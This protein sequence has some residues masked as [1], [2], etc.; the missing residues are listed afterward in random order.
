MQLSPKPPPA[1]SNSPINLLRG[2][3]SNTSSPQQTTAVEDTLNIYN[4]L[5]DLPA[6]LQ[7]DSVPYNQG[8]TVDSD[9]SLVVSSDD[10]ELPVPKELKA[11]DLKRNTESTLSTYSALC[12][13]FSAVSL[14]VPPI[15]MN[16][17]DDAWIIVLHS[18]FT[19]NGVPTNREGVEQ[20]LRMAN[21]YSDQL[22]NNPT[23]CLG[24]ETP[25]YYDDNGELVAH[26]FMIP[27]IKTHIGNNS[28]DSLFP[29]LEAKII[30]SISLSVQY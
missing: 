25:F 9:T 3:H 29:K 21:E 13:A 2:F 17:Q 14:E 20:Y 8:S 7:Q 24:W 16:P 1:R 5:A 30:I 22:L 23:L 6:Y 11:A 19:Q 15:T 18:M 26:Q 12:D 28:T 4:S 10:D 27:V